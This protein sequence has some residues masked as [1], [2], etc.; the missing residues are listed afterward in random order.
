MWKAEWKSDDL[1][2]NGRQGQNQHGVD[3]C[4]HRDGRR[5]YWGIQ[6]KCK[7]AGETLTEVEIVKE[8]EKAKQFNPPLKHLLIATS[9]EKDA[10]IEEFVRLKDEALR[11]EGLFSLDIKSW[12]DIV[13]LLESHR[14]VAEWYLDVISDDFD[15]EVC[16]PGDKDVLEG[17]AFFLRV[18]NSKKYYDGMESLREEY[19]YS[20]VSYLMEEKRLY[21]KNLSYIDIP[22]VIKNQ[23]KSP[24]DQYKLKLQFD[25]DVLLTTSISKHYS[26]KSFVLDSNYIMDMSL[27]NGVIEYCPRFS[28]VPGDSDKIPLFYVKAKLGTKELILRW[29]L[30]SR[31]YHTS[32]LLHVQ[33]K[34]TIKTIDLKSCSV[35]IEEW[36]VVDWIHMKKS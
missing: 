8:I 16:F 2:L 33:I 34:E 26:T 31:K 17:E 27:D 36:E 18:P 30:L 11:N 19:S 14:D 7:Q 35:P 6:C 4:G 23:G 21:E 1:K 5:G 9:S 20:A 12:G 32:G 29:E 3:I 15:I 22:L 13:Y 28:L 24:I 25:Q 10:N